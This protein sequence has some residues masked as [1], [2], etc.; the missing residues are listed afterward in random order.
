MTGTKR[1]LMIGA[2]LALLAVAGSAVGMQMAW[3]SGFYQGADVALCVV[4]SVQNDGKFATGDK[5]CARAHV[6]EHSIFWR[7]REH[8]EK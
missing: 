6:G 3:Q 5:A 1:T 4:A 8:H 7:F 2:P